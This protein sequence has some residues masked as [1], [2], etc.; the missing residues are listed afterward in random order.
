M[1]REISKKENFGL[2]SPWFDPFFE[3]DEEA[4]NFGVLSMDT[5]IKEENGNY[6][7]DVELPGF[8]KKN[9]S[10]DMKDGYLTISAKA[11]RSQDEKDK[12]GNYIHRERFSGMAS[13]SYY[14]GDVDEKAVKA[15]Y[16]D[17]VLSLTFPKEE[18]KKAENKHTIAIE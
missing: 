15:N 6:V 5:D 11:N 8:D 16:K 12:K 2:L 13:R 9:I 4:K 17:G 10:V 1:N 3:D 18:I 7:L 14:V